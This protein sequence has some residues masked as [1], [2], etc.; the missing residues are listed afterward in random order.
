MRALIVDD[1]TPARLKLRGLL[2]GEPDV[3][4]VGEARDGAEAVELVRAT[5][6]DL[7]F[8]DVQ[9]P[10]VDGFGVVEQVGPEATPPIVF[11]TAFDEHAVRAFEVHAL[12]YL[13]KPV[14]PQRFRAALARVRSHLA[15]RTAADA[16]ATADRLR[17]LLAA[18]GN[19]GRYLRRVLVHEER[20]ALFLPVSRI[21]RIEADRNYVRL[22]VGEASYE[23]R[24][25]LSEF[26]RRLDPQQ[27]LRI[28]KSDI[29][30]LD[31]V[32]ELH[33]WSHGDYRVVLASGATVT[34]SRRYRSREIQAFSPG[35][36]S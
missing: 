3:A 33:P 9:M 22:H 13:L 34:W 21:E 6:P 24:A 1:E 4:V 20:R 15:Q 17:E 31:A 23:L 29:V 7:V 11:V 26:E 27:F 14:T 2:A 25:T 32:K 28:S 12:D 16:A 19:P 30:R 35:R 10:V 8:L 36:E 5:R 18:A